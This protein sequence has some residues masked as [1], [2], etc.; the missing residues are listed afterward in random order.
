[1]NNIHTLSS[2]WENTGFYNASWGNLCMIL[3]GFILIYLA[4]K[5]SFKPLLLIPLG[6]GVILGNIPFLHEAAYHTGI[7][8]EGSVLNYLFFGVLKGIYPALIFP[9]SY[10]HLRA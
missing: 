3:V 4:I 5:H 10:T 8:Q 6:M 1:M 9:V 7:Y 2:L